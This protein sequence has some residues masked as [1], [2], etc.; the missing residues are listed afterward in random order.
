MN[1][2]PIDRMWQRIEIDRQDLD[3]TLGLSLL[4]FGEL[5]IK[6]VGVGLVAAIQ[7]DRER[8][9]YRQMHR[10]VRADGIGEWVATI[11]DIPD[12]PNTSASK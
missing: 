11:D 5:V 10:L 1:F 2:L 7:N 4:Y 8:H 6:I 9:R 3:T 12:W